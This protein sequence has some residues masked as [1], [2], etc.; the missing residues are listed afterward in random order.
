ML[1][2]HHNATLWFHFYHD[3][4]HGGAFLNGH[5][6]VFVVFWCR[7]WC[8]RHSQKC[9]YRGEHEVHY[10]L[11]PSL[12]GAVLVPPVPSAGTFLA[13]KAAANRTCLAE[14]G[15]P[16]LFPCFL[17][18]VRVL[19]SI[20]HVIPVQN[21]MPSTFC[22]KTKP[23]RVFLVFIQI[24]VCRL[25][26]RD[27]VYAEYGGSLVCDISVSNIATED[28]LTAHYRCDWHIRSLLTRAE[29]INHLLLENSSRT[30]C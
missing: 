17:V 8:S 4:G 27:L 6:P 5:E 11:F 20:N 22:D 15:P 1:L 30:S 21:V 10:R 7:W 24:Y 19:G 2:A 14:Y 16:F 12:E 23:K 26:G 18:S 25:L 28:R 29:V 9:K 3:R 13:T